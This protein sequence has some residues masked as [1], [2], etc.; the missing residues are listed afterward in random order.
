MSAA[1][2]LVKIFMPLINK[3]RMNLLVQPTDIFHK[4]SVKHKGECVLFKTGLTQLLNLIPIHYSALNA[5]YNI[6]FSH[7]L[8]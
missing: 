8:R 4:S 7:I 5:L 3:S 1:V 6:Y 2:V